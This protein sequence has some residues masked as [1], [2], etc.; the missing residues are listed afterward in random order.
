MQ[1]LPKP[2]VYLRALRYTL[3]AAIPDIY[4]YSWP[5]YNK[6]YSYTSTQRYMYRSFCIF[7]RQVRPLIDR[8]FGIIFQHDRSFKDFF[9]I[10]L[11]RNVLP[12]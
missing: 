11:K 3:T 10:M 4:I 9:T 7:V 8:Q 6:S 2:Y 5:L 12:P 1:N